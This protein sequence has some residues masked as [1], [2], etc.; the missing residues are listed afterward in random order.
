[1]M[2][3]IIF[4]AILFLIVNLPGYIRKQL[5]QT[6]AEESEKARD[7]FQLSQLNQLSK[8]EWL[9]L[10]PLKKVVITALWFVCLFYSIRGIFLTISDYRTSFLWLTV[11]LWIITLL[12]I[13]KV[14][15]YVKLPY[16]CIPVLNH[17]YTKEELKKS[18]QGEC[19]EKVFFQHSILRK[20]F[21]VLISENWVIIDGYLI[22]RNAVKKIYY[23]HESPIVNYEQI[24]FIYF[25]DEEFHLPSERW[26]A[27]AMRQTEISQVLHKI[28]PEVIEKAEEADTSR[29]KDKSIIYW[30]MNYKGKFRRTLWFIPLVVILCFLTPVFMG[31]FWFVYDIILIAILIWQLRYTYKKMK[32]EETT[33]HE[34]KDAENKKDTIDLEHDD[35]AR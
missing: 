19:F 8:I 14:W 28:S 34:Q 2:Y 35:S 15:R 13:R 31:S 33:L 20:Y 9:R 16:H 21:H 10:Y 22:S 24:K 30:N 6:I 26:S 18:L 29:G 32:F 4:V 25:N 12:T 17:L 7:H 5:T 11:I 3:G 23:L 1:M 27:N